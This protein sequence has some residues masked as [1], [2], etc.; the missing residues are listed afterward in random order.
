MR[1]AARVLRRPQQH[2]QC[3]TSQRAATR[4][5]QNVIKRLHAQNLCNGFAEAAERAACWDGQAAG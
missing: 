2:R 3:S 4:R 1:G 5:V